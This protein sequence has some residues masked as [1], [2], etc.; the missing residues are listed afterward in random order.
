VTWRLG[1]AGSIEKSTDGGR[2]WQIQVSG[3]NVD[4]IAGSAS[5]DRVAWV[6]GG[7]SVIL[8]T[9][10]GQSWTRIAPPAAVT[11]QWSVIAAHDAMTATLFTN[12]FRRFTTTDGGQTWSLEP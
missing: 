8:R 10:D 7:S 4:L 6:I 1:D 12:D 2:T 5:S 9:T 3:V 11:A